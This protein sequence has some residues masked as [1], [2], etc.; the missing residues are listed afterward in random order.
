MT[1]YDHF[2]LPGIWIQIHWPDWIRSQSDS[3]PET[4]LKLEKEQRFVG[5]ILFKY[6]CYVADTTAG[7]YSPLGGAAAAT[8]RFSRQGS[9]PSPARPRSIRGQFFLINK[10]RISAAIAASNVMW[11]SLSLSTVVPLVHTAIRNFWHPH[12]ESGSSVQVS[13]SGG[14]DT[15]PSS[16]KQK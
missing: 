5:D 4:L 7:T 15:D 13:R 11:N 14:T 2:G 12:F 9:N 3:V 10:A 6:D 8:I 16:I 1:K